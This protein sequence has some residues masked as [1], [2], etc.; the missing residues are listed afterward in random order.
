MQIFHFS[1][2]TLIAMILFPVAANAHCDGAKHSG[3]HPHCDSGDPPPPPPSGCTDDF[4]G[5]LYSVDETR[6][7]PGRL[8]LAST[9]GCRS[10]PVGVVGVTTGRNFHMTA[11]GTSGVILWT[12]R[13]EGPGNGARES[14]VRQDF[15]VD[16]N[17]T[18][19]LLDPVTILPWGGEDDPEGECARYYASDVWGDAT[20]NSLYLIVDRAY[21]C[22]SGPNAGGGTQELL[23]YDLNDLTGDPSDPPPDVRVVWESESAGGVRQYSNWLDAGDPENLPDCSAVSFPQFVPTCYGDDGFRINSSGT[24]LYVR[25]NFDDTLGDR[26]DGTIRL[27]IDKSTIGPALNQWLISQPELVYAGTSYYEPNGMLAR[28]DSDFSVLPSPEII[29]MSYFD[30]SAQVTVGVSAYMNADQ[31]V[32]VY[33]PLSAGDQD[34]YPD[35]WMQCITY[36]LFLPNRSGSWESPD[37]ILRTER[38]K[39]TQQIHRHH[40]SGASPGLTELLIDNGGGADNGN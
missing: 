10:E 21:Y 5:F 1:A 19:D 30:K 24:R 25:D 18:L 16:T 36:D 3:N 37:T 11:D 9:N 33:A 22:D 17:G 20:H 29:G 13:Q 4:P 12:D 38:P 14:I 40:I 6:K 39:R 34:G 28:P 31:C 23:I 26:W 8:Y 35:L 7:N 2:L 32:G 27:D 15:T